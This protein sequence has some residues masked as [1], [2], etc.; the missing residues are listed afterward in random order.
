MPYSRRSPAKAGARS[1][2][3][4]PLRLDVNGFFSPMIGSWGLAPADLEAIEPRLRG[5]L[6]SIRTRR[7][8]GEFPFHDLAYDEAGAAECSRLAD[9]LAADFDTMI[10]LGIGGSALGIKAVLDAVPAF[11]RP[12]RM[13]VHVAD[14][15]DPSSFSALLDGVDLARTCF[16]V[17]S[18]SGGTSETLAHFLV[19]RERLAAVVGGEQ[20]PRHIVVTTDPE[21][22]PKLSV[23]ADRQG[24]TG[25]GASLRRRSHDARRTDRRR[26]P[27]R[28]DASSDAHRTNSIFAP[29]MTSTT[30][31]SLRS[32]NGAAWLAP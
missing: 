11:V 9:E 22:G 30:A 23:N 2:A 32:V 6:E 29:A 16:K 12:R 15:V 13:D 26:A 24:A 3:V 28:S 21:K 8:R 27:A 7:E 25:T 14:N 18:K 4:T 1:P 17:I 19:V 31:S 20:W 10:V 5:V